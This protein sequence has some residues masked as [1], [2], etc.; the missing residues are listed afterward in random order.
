MRTRTARGLKDE[1]KPTWITW[2]NP[3]LSLLMCYVKSLY[4]AR[5]QQ[6]NLFGKICFNSFAP[7]VLSSFFLLDMNSRETKFTARREKQLS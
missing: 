2:G 5:G 3:R 1:N 7:L 4:T 6:D